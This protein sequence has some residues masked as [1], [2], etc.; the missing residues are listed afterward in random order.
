[1]ALSWVAFLLSILPHL[2]GY[3]LETRWAA[4]RGI[5]DQM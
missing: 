3:L 1:M 4:E 5:L 2:V